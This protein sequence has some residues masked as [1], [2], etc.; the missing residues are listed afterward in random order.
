MQKQNATPDMLQPNNV[1]AEEA[2][3]GSILIDYGVLIELDDFCPLSPDDFFVERNAWIYQAMLNLRAK[4]MA[5]DNLTLSDELEANGVLIE[6]GGPAKLTQ[7]VAD[8]FT[9]IHGAYYARIIKDCSDRRKLIDLAGKL[10]REAWDR[11]KGLA[12]FDFDML[13]TDMTAAIKQ[14]QVEVLTSID[15]QELEKVVK[16]MQWLWEN[17]IPYGEISAIG[18]R[19]GTGKSAMVQDLIRRCLNGQPMPDGQKPNLRSDRILF[20]D[21]EDF[22]DDFVGRMRTWQQCGDEQFWWRRDGLEIIQ[23]PKKK[24][25]DLATIEQQNRL[26]DIVA[27]FKPTWIILDSWQA[28]ILKSTFDEQIAHVIA[29]FKALIKEFNCALTTTIQLNK[30]D[31]S[32]YSPLSSTS[33]KGAGTAAYRFRATYGMYRMQV[34]GM[35]DLKKDPRILQP[36]RISSALHPDPI[37]FTF[38]PLYPRGFY[39]QYHKFDELHAIQAE[40]VPETMLTKTEQAEDFIVNYLMVNGAQSYQDL[41]EAARQQKIGT[42]TVEEVVKMLRNEGR[43][44][45][46]LGERK[47]QN[48]LILTEGFS[49]MHE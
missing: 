46:T 11:N 1:E 17:Y 6:I 42:S 27:R 20:I 35:K 25:L 30:D 41:K 8:A 33:F 40:Q 31:G 10:A 4:G 43:I 36:I 37:A 2:L 23:Y 5:I 26:V 49:E 24:L 47:P 28:A 44:M 19:E 7:L 13:L 16:P 34:G 45:N 18:G 21:A 38:E 22:V 32:P 14:V 48:K 39:V 3:L 12:D 15:A 9:S 29:F